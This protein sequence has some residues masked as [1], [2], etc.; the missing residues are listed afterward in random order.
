MKAGFRQVLYHNGVAMLPR[1]KSEAWLI[2]ALKSDPGVACDRLEERSG[3]DG[4]PNS[5]KR[6]LAE[7]LG[8]ESSGQ[9]LAD[10]VHDGT[11][12]PRTIKMSS[13]EVF[14]T[15]LRQV[16]DSVLGGE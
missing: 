14:K 15:E 12:D 3:N 4:S 6:E 1:P 8:H 11:I 7:I 9:E 13:F 10:L 5:L 2:C 16:V